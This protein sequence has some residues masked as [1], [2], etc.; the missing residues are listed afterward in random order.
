MGLGNKIRK[1]IDK[2]DPIAL[3]QMD[4]VKLMRRTDTK[5]VL[6]KEL[7]PQLLKKAVDNYYMVEIEDKREQIYKTTYFDTIDYKMYRLHHNG[8]KNRYKIRFIS[9]NSC[10]E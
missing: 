6:S 2:F 4:K 1:V 5:F 9:K 3:D 10:C 7:F 8:V